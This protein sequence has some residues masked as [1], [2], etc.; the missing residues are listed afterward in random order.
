MQFRTQIRQPIYRVMVR[1]CPHGDADA[2]TWV[3][4][5]KAWWAGPAR[6]G[7]ARELFSFCVPRPDGDEGEVVAAALEAAAAAF[8]G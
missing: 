8:R 7:E 1:R 2:S 5:T 6:G 3:R 4:V